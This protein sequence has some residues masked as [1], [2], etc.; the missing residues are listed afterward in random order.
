VSW[1][2]TL[3]NHLICFTEYGCHPG[4][5]NHSFLAQEEP[6]HIFVRQPEP[7]AWLGHP[8]R[9]VFARRFPGYLFHWQA[10]SSMA[11]KVRA[12]QRFLSGLAA[13][14]RH[15]RESPFPARSQSDCHSLVNTSLCSLVWTTRLMLHRRSLLGIADQISK[16]VCLLIVLVA[17]TWCQSLGARRQP[18]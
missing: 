1:S 9:G 14:A 11:T 12:P 15:S 13:W 16:Y 4:W 3:V 2:L 7:N 18:R 6:P 10:G 8:N 17:C 5:D